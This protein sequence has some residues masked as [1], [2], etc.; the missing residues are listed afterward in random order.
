M[1]NCR[2]QAA[3]GLRLTER[4]DQHR[5]GAGIFHAY[6]ARRGCREV[7]YPTPMERPP[8]GDLC[9]Y[10]FMISKVGD[11][12]Q[13]S[14]FQSPVGQGVERRV[15]TSATG[16]FAARKAWSIPTGY[17]LLL[18]M[19]CLMMVLLMLA[20]GWGMVFGKG[21]RRQKNCQ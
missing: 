4:D 10:R 3:V 1:E 14:Q 6:R 12:N 7:C 17:A 18:I 16:C 9:D 8:V 20:I 11:A 21:D 2:K 19:A 13:R 5:G 15:K